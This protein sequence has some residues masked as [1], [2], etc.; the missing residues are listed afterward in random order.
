MPKFSA[1]LSFLY[2]E[3]GFL[4]R[5]A[6]AAKDGFKAVEYLGPYAEPK[7]KVAE[8]LEANGLVQALFNVPSG[9]WAGGERGTRDRKS[10]V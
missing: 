3:H 4:E 10:V 5:F 7:E 1:N 2:Q 9:D 8:T 6:A